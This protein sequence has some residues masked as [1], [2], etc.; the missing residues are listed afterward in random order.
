MN[1]TKILNVAR[2]VS[3]PTQFDV[4]LYILL[5][6][7]SKIDL[8]VY[9]WRG[10]ELDTLIDPELGQ[11]PGWDFAMTDGYN[12]QLLPKNS[13]ILWRMLGEHIFKKDRYDL[14]LVSGWGSM[15]ARLAIL[16][17]IL[18]HAPLVVISDTTMLYRRKNWRASIRKVILKSLFKFVP[19]FGVTGSLA[20][21]HL[22]VLGVPDEK[23]F[24]FPYTIDVETF[25]TRSNEVRRHKV[26][27]RREMGLSP[28]DLIFLVVAKFVPREGVRE[29]LLAYRNIVKQNNNVGLLIVGDGQ[30]REELKRF[31]HEY[32][33]ANVTFTGYQP[34][35]QLHK[36][37]GISDAFIHAAREESWGV[38]VNEAMACALPIIASDR[39]GAT[40][41]LIRNSKEGFIYAG[42]A[43][44]A[45]TK[46]MQHFINLPQAARE[47]MGAH[48]ADMMRGWTYT[49][50][51]AEIIRMAEYFRSQQ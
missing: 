6:Q 36:F 45:L 8:M 15:V 37:Y 31:V 39:V 26:E 19:A 41:D 29:V 32:H 25:R 12:W 38:S 9:Y 48:A 11:P 51:V 43:P 22:N 24:L 13:C 28:D 40:Y 27:I 10:V 46:A 17:G 34:Y 20:R 4:P 5:R 49:N 42:S 35:S 21:T 3:H 14:V 44:E 23:I 18:M 16:F 1:Q 7:T 47:E 50:V 30:Q 33:L 2:I